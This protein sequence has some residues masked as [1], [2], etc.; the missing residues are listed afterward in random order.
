MKNLLFILIYLVLN[1]ICIS[2][3]EWQVTYGPIDP[4]QNDVSF[5]NPNTGFTAGYASGNVRILKTTNK[6]VNWSQ[7]Q[8]LTSDYYFS[9]S[10]GIH[11]KTSTLGF[12]SYYDKIVKFDDGTV[13]TVFTFPYVS[14]WHRLKF[15]SNDVG[16]ALF[17]YSNGSPP[18]YQSYVSI[19]KTT[20]GGNNWFVTSANN[21]LTQYGLSR[22]SYLRDIDFSETNSD[23]LHAVG[24]YVDGSL[25]TSV[26]ISTT[27]GFSSRTVGG[28]AVSGSRF[29]HVDVLSNDEIIILGNKGLKVNTQG[30]T[31][32]DLRYSFGNTTGNPELGLKFINNQIGYAAIQ[33][34]KVMKTTNG[35][36]NWSIETNIESTTYDHY[37]SR[38]ISIGEIVYYASAVNKNFYTKRLY[39]S[40]SSFFDNQ[41]N[42]YSLNFDGNNYST[43]SN[44][45]LRGGFSQVSADL[46]INSGQ[47]NERLFYKWNDNSMNNNHSGF[48]FDMSGTSIANYYKTKQLSTT[49][50]AIT[51]IGQTK[52]LK[53]EWGAINQIHQSLGGGIFFTKSY[54]NG[55]TFKREEIVNSTTTHQVADGNKNPALCETKWYGTL[56]GGY[57]VN[58]NVA[59]CWERYNSSNN[60][61]EIK[62]AVRDYNI[63]SDTVFSWNSWEDGSYSDLFA[64]FGSSSGYS[65]HPKVFALAMDPV[66]NLGNPSTYFF[67]VPHLRPYSGGS[68]LYVA[69]RKGTTTSAEFALD[70]GDISDI[71]AIDSAKCGFGYLEINFAYRKGNQI[72]YRNTAFAYQ[73]GYPIA[74]YNLEG[75]ID[76]ATGDGGFSS[77]LTPDISLMNNVPVITY[78]ANYNAWRLVEFEDNSTETIPVN[79]Y[80]IVKVQ[81]TGTNIW[82]NYVIYNS[83]NGQYNPDI[84]GSKSTYSYL[85]NYSLGNDQFKKVVSVYQNP[86]YICQPNIFSGTDSRLINNS[87]TG[88]YGSN[89]RLLT[90]SPQSSLYKIDKQDFVI[91]NITSA[92]S[93]DISNLDGVINLDTIKYSFRLGPIYVQDGLGGIEGGTFGSG[94]E[95]E[96]PM[97]TNVEFNENLKS[98][99]FLLNEDQAL[100]IGACGTYLKDNGYY[101]ISEIP[102]SVKL[103]NHSTGQLHRVLFQDT[104]HAEDSIETEYLRGFFMTD[105]P[106][107]EDSFYVKLEP[108]D[109]FD[110]ANYFINPIYD[111]PFGPEGPDNFS[112]RKLAV[113]FENEN[114][115]N[116]LVSLP[117]EYSLSQNY[118]N[119]FNPVTLI[120]YSIPFSGWISLKVFDIQGREIQTLVNE[121]K[122][123]GN[124]SIKFDGSSF[125]SGVYFYKIESDN[126]NQT[127][128]MILIK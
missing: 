94:S 56:S 111:D 53:D 73:S 37:S 91:T 80:P 50:E 104:V 55:T 109:A 47:T 71:S 63:F 97:L 43:P 120:N 44:E 72:V 12:I 122:N 92:D 33:S 107:D 10:V 8:S 26:H 86:G 52:A 68:K 64:S 79:R 40:L 87:Y 13:S 70:S 88:L 32:Y 11:F 82:S 46:I 127:R 96:D 41:S 76:V 66:Y 6:G 113:I 38:I 125:S 20:N 58:K 54:N 110:N 74:K 3:S 28:D 14:T 65:S 15:V 31:N 84:E 21:I 112:A 99:P 42:S 24:Y 102:Y 98:Y 30:Q 19:Y 29:G 48:Y 34:G 35:G 59:A 67:I 9:H 108:D 81:R 95:A 85:L 69:C 83:S 4:T 89:L 126:F 18:A 62:V 75:P 1:K 119:P 57:P 27:N 77:R 22:Q 100:L 16:Y 25:G 103:Y 7:I 23:I 106:N 49:S 118:P 114:T 116:H 78:A 93:Y 45:Y 117:I 115:S 124:Y 90:L 17:S 128:R 2:Q 61:T 51:N 39:S 101:D 36:N 60:T 5:I 121:F 105:I 123:A